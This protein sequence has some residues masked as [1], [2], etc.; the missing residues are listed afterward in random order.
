[1]E[2]MEALLQASA[3]SGDADNIRKILS[4]GVSPNASDSVSKSFLNIPI[5]LTRRVVSPF[6]Q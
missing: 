4:N 3:N 5:N 2:A 1:M 6:G